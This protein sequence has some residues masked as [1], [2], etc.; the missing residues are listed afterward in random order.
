MIVS[1]AWF[2]GEMVRGACQIGADLLAHWAEEFVHERC[3]RRH[4]GRPAHAR[5]VLVSM[6][7]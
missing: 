7:V 6:R 4:R 2:C 1:M 5:T 3:L